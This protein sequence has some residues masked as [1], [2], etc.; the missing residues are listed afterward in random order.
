MLQLSLRLIQVQPGSRSFYCDEND[1]VPCVCGC[2]FTYQQPLVFQ[3]VC[4]S[5]WIANIRRWCNLTSPSFSEGHFSRLRTLNPSQRQSPGLPWQQA[6]RNHVKAIL[7]HFEA[8][9]D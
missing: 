7:I 9:K 5:G 2:V 1:R 4:A 3:G 6:Q 8:P